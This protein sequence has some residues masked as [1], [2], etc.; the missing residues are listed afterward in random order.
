MSFEAMATVVKR[1]ESLLETAQEQVVEYLRSRL[2]LCKTSLSGIVYLRKR[3]H[4]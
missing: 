2:K 1:M 3:N 4:N